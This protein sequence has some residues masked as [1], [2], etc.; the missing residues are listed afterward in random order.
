MFLQGDHT[1]RKCDEDI[2]SDPLTFNNTLYTIQENVLS[3]KTTMQNGRKC[4]QP[5]KF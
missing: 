4:F 2:L 3:E 5:S 1:D